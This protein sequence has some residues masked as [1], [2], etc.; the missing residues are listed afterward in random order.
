MLVT[1]KTFPPTIL[2]LLREIF[3]KNMC[4]W[5]L[6]S[7]LTKLK[8][9][10]FVS[11][12]KKNNWGN[13]SFSVQQLQ[14]HS[15]ISCQRCHLYTHGIVWSFIILLFCDWCA[16]TSWTTRYSRKKKIIQSRASTL[17]LWIHVDL[18]RTIKKY[19]H[20]PWSIVQP[21][22]TLWKRCWYT[23]RSFLFILKIAMW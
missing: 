5:L 12:S 13:Y 21:Y 23:I 9:K 19:Q 3:P 1:C 17:W 2:V 15:S 18:E 11:K 4:E 7:F 16:A 20:I 10:S 22:G 8:K 6:A 14:L